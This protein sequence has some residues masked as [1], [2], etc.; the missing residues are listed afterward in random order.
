[1]QPTTA[2]WMP[3]Y[4]GDYLK[5]TGHLSTLE[6]GAYL[7]LIGHYWGSGRPL[8][9]DDAVLARIVRLNRPAWR[10]VRPAIEPFFDCRDGLWHHRRIERELKEAAANKARRVDSA[11]GA[12]SARWSRDASRMPDAMRQQCPSPSSSPSPGQPP[13]EVVPSSPASVP[14]EPLVGARVH[15]VGSLVASLAAVKRVAP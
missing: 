10:K 8:P 2:I 4:W 5:N 1:M 3:L 11:R 12:A 14:A 6:H 13:S 7:L 9:D 15:E